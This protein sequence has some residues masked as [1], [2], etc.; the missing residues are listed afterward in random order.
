MC[1]ISRG[2]LAPQDAVHH[3]LPLFSSNPSSAWHSG[4]LP[5]AESVSS[6]HTTVLAMECPRAK[7]RK[8]KSMRLKVNVNRN[9]QRP[10]MCCVHRETDVVLGMLCAH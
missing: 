1:Y 5:A 9:M 2:K 6:V 4:H 7:V 3:A 8:L 10:T